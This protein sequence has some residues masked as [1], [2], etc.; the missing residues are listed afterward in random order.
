MIHRIEKIEIEK[1]P[2]IVNKEIIPNSYCLNIKIKCE[3]YS[4]DIDL[5]SQNKQS[6]KI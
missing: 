5:F 2:H 6:L 1:K 4:F 3:G